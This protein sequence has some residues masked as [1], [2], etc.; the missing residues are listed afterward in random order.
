MVPV[1]P[2]VE[3]RLA[4]AQAFLIVGEIARATERR[5]IASRAFFSGA[6]VLHRL[7]EDNP[8]N[9]RVRYRFA[10]GFRQFVSQFSHEPI[11]PRLLAR[12]L[13]VMDG[14]CTERPENTDYAYERTLLKNAKEAI[15]WFDKAAAVLEKHPLEQ[16]YDLKA[17][18]FLANTY[19]GRYLAYLR[20]KK[21]PEAEEDW[22]RTLKH[23]N[24]Q[25]LLELRVG[26]AFNL[27]LEGYFD[28]ALAASKGLSEATAK[29][30]RHTF[31]LLRTYA[32][33]GTGFTGKD[34][35][36]ASASRD[37]ALALLR[38]AKDLGMLRHE[39]ARQELKSDKMFAFLRENKEFQELLSA[40][41]SPPK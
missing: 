19:W 23:L 1:I 37:Q 31:N 13:E 36:K 41:E 33:I 32:L 40:S 16:P 30:S 21:L 6:D 15:E 22:Q 25:R 20:L 9:E 2:E 7:L 38:R 18:E 4:E 26:K 27:A 17:R 11:V 35:Q 14:L 5:E 39:S 24:E 8:K 12:A 34:E 10:V 29:E 3:V 28:E